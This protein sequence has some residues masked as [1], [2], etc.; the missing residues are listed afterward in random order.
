MHGPLARWLPLFFSALI[1]AVTANPT[2]AQ[3]TPHPAR[4]LHLESIEWLTDGAEFL[5][6]KRFKTSMT[7]EEKARRQQ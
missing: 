4:G 6:K 7:R 5:D 2:T 1:A 3:A